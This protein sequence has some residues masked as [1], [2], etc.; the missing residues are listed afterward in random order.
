MLVIQ[1]ATLKQAGKLVSALLQLPGLKPL[2]L[3]N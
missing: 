1:Q 2:N 3:K